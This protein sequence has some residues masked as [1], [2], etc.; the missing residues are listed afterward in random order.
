MFG[1]GRPDVLPVGDLGLKAGVK[2]F[3]D[4]AELPSKE[5]LEELAEPWRPYRSIGTWY[6]WRGLGGLVPHSGDGKK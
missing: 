1:L 4:L 3:W 5:D 6:I 2:R